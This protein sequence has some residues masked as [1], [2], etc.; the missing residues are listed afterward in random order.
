MDTETL[1]GVCPL[2]PLSGPLPTLLHGPSLLSGSFSLLFLFHFLFL[3][4][5]SIPPLPPYSDSL[6]SFPHHN[7]SPSHS[8]LFLPFLSPLS[9][10]VF[11]FLIFYLFIFRQ[12]GRGGEREGEKHEEEKHQCVVASHAP[13][14]GD[15]AHNPGMCP[16]WESN[17]QPFGLQACA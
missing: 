1:P 7:H 13:P 11:F 16:N 5:F 2:S 17:L 3:A 8:I 12:R 14:T 15:L 9:L 4:V 10:P 6:A